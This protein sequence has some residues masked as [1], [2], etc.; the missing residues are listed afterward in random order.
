MSELLRQVIIQA[1]CHQS[2][3]A[4]VMWQLFFSSRTLAQ[5]NPADLH[6]AV[7]RGRVEGDVPVVGRSRV[8]PVG[9]PVVGHARHR[10]HGVSRLRQVWLVDHHQAVAQVH[11]ALIIIINHNY[12]IKN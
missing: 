7:G 3:T 1:R 5:R 8:R 4:V 11:R 2:Q 10:G 9:T 6:S 12:I